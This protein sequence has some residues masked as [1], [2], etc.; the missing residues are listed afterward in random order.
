MVSLNRQK[1]YDFNNKIWFYKKKLIK[2]NIQNYKNT[3]LSN[4]L[5][6]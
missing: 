4:V 5:K 6:F 3:F 1:L 2:I